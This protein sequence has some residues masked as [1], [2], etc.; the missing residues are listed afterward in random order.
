MMLSTLPPA[1]DG[2]DAWHWLGLAI[3]LSYSLGLNRGPAQLNSTIRK[4]RLERRIWWSAFT[5][6]RTLA[7]S[8]ART[9]RIRHEDCDVPMLSL[10]DFELDEGD[11]TP[12]EIR[13]RQAAMQ[14]VEKAMLCWCS[15]DQTLVTSFPDTPSP[16][17]AKPQHIFIPQPRSE[18]NILEISQLGDPSTSVSSYE[19]TSPLFSN[20]PNSEFRS[21]S[22]PSLHEDCP[23]PI[24]EPILHVPMGKGDLGG[25]FSVDGEYDDYLEYLKPLP[26]I[27]AVNGGVGGGPMLVEKMEERGRETWA[28]QLDCEN[29]RVLEV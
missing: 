25:G 11:E 3:S 8:G 7:L 9:I 16:H 4:K 13:R 2:K 15:N 26:S 6:D 5:H 21:S 24:E 12:D 10:P 18:P 22:S 20:P 27:E 23:T 1:H 19:T 29:D 17:P 28:F 14:C